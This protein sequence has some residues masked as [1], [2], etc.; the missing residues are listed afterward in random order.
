MPKLCESQRWRAESSSSNAASSIAPVGCCA[1]APARPSGPQSRLMTPCPPRCAKN[2]GRRGAQ[3]GRG[4]PV[5]FVGRRAQES[6]WVPRR[7]GNNRLTPS[8]T[9]GRTPVALRR[10]CA[11]PTNFVKQVWGF[12]G[13]GASTRMVSR[14]AGNRPVNKGTDFDPS[15]LGRPVL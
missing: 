9:S 4:G 12:G 7:K 3:L 15:N 13:R 11:P 8:N 6:N 1:K 2:G 10:W 14:Q 5:R